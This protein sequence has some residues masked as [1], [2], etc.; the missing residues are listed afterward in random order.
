MLPTKAMMMRE[1]MNCASYVSLYVIYLCGRMR[2]HERDDIPAS[3][4]GRCSKLSTP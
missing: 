3:L 4:E 1:Q 2:A